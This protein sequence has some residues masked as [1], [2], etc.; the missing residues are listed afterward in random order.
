MSVEAI[1]QSLAYCRGAAEC[2]A[3]EAAELRRAGAAAAVFAADGATAPT[4]GCCSATSCPS[5]GKAGYKRCE[6]IT[7]MTDK[8]AI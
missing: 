8:I 4:A 3:A 2:G 6:I 5:H 1:T 7:V